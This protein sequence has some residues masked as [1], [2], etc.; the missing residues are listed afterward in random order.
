MLEDI[1]DRIDPGPQPR[2]SEGLP[3]WMFEVLGLSSA[4]RD[5]SVT[6]LER[7][8][9]EQAAFEAALAGGIS[10][11]VEMVVALRALARSMV[12]AEQAA[13]SGSPDADTLARLERVYAAL[14]EP[15]VASD[16]SSFSQLLVVFAQTAQS[17]GELPEAAQLGEL[18]DVVQR[19]V[20]AAGPLHRH[21]VAALLRAAPEHDAVPTA[22][23]EV[24]SSLRGHDDRWSVDLA[25]LAIERRGG[26]AS[27]Q[28][29]LELARACFAALEL[30]C[31]DAALAASR[32]AAVTPSE[33]EAATVEGL[34]A[35][36]IV[37]LAEAQTPDERIERARAQLELGRFDAARSAFEALR[38]ELPDDARPV[39]GLAKLA[40]DTKLDFLG[41]HAI[42]E[43]AGSVRNAD[44]MYYELAIGTRAMAIL[45]TTVPRLAA[46]EAQGA[47]TSLRPSLARMREDVA[48]YA[49]LGNTDGVYLGFVLDVVQELLTQYASTGEISIPDVKSLSDRAL[50]LQRS[51]PDNP[52]AY[53]L[54]QSASLFEADE[55]V[56]ARAT[57]VPPPA[58][59]EHDALENRRVRAL[60]DLAVTWA[61]PT[62]AEQA[63]DGSASLGPAGAVLRADTLLIMT[64][65]GRGDDWT[66]VGEAYQALLADPM[67]SADAR[68]LNNVAVSLWS[69]GNTSTARDAWS[70]SAQLGEDHADVARLNLIVS[71]LTRGEAVAELEALARDG[72]VAGVRL[73]AR[74]WLL[75]EAKGA[76]TK[77]RAA[78]LRAAIAK[79][80]EQTMRPNAPDP[81]VGVLL[82]GSLSAGL[83]YAT[84]AGLQIDLDSSGVPWAIRVPQRPKSARAASHGLK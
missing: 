23:L 43:E 58:G 17:E 59:A 26:A 35:R 22:L 67:T 69:S 82:E 64:A 36:R 1:A 40:I 21:T 2:I 13:A 15:M 41:A 57:Q 38:A 79:E 68:A 77:R 33:L 19:S 83:G 75:A 47:L 20:Q 45:A 37:A 76:Q 56:A 49:G 65:L 3:A 46:G 25:T 66:R 61:N 42:I 62:F 7:S 74:A 44:A 8:A 81:Y 84:E 6:L 52:H 63:L 28:E 39:A 30:G 54:L 5:P 14:D 10:D 48:G 12:L 11:N 31:G 4:V 72:R 80:R 60:A 53:R 78:E 29:Q 9:A 34:L 71:D 24:A 73:V 32:A 50:A 70:L 16:R 51:I 55:A 27:G 18:A